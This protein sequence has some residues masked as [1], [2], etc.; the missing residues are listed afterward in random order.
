[1]R[2]P[3][4][5]RA[6]RRACQ[7][8][9]AIAAAA[10]AIAGTSVSAFAATAPSSTQPASATAT[11]S[12]SATESP[13]STES[14]DTVYFAYGLASSPFQLVSGGSIY[15]SNQLEATSSPPPADCQIGTLLRY[16]SSI[17]SLNLLES[18][19]SG[20]KECSTLIGKPINTPA[21]KCVISPGKTDFYTEGIT[22]LITPDGSTSSDTQD[23]STT[24]LYCT[25]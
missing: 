11:Q 24:D 3:A 16:G 4:S 19:Y 21:Y 10:A 7:A 15:A 12:A 2:T 5:V 18:E 9:L 6:R 22:Y 23:T 14:P 20:Y 25:A 13:A 1:M 8:A 17:T